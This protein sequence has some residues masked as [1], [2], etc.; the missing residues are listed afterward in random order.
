MSMQSSGDLAKEFITVYCWHAGRAI[1]FRAF[2]AKISQGFWCWQRR[3]AE[4][5]R[6]ASWILS[7]HSSSKG[8]QS[9]SWCISIM[10]MT[11]KW[12]VTPSD[13]WLTSKGQTIGRI[14]TWAKSTRRIS[15]LLWRSECKIENGFLYP[16]HININTWSRAVLLELQSD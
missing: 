3:Q 5:Q 11:M 12:Q 10:I 4:F 14:E 15:C 8:W 7:P 9:L 2:D 16:C 6:V 1:L 13:V